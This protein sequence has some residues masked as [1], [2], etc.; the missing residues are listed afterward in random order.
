MST[1]AHTPWGLPKAPRMPVCRWEN[2]IW[3]HETH[4][5]EAA[6][7]HHCSHEHGEY[8]LGTEKCLSTSVM[9]RQRSTY[10]QPIGTGARQHLVDAQHVE[11]VHADA[12]VEGVL[13]R[14]LDHVLVGGN[15]RRLQ[16]LAR[17][18]LLLPAARRAP[19]TSEVVTASAPVCTCVHAATTSS[20]SLLLRGSII[21]KQ[22]PRHVVQDSSLLHLLEG[23]RFHSSSA[24]LQKHMA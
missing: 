3:T 19:F 14:V 17:D 12:Q 9:V 18:L 15:A 23:R 4:T 16:R 13:A 21:L 11:G 20:W 22:L 5:I 7:Q 8:E 2:S 6:L 1:R 10:L 24:R